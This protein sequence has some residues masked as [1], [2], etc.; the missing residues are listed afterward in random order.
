MS[1]LLS[2]L[3]GEVSSDV[4][5][6]L[7]RFYK[8]FN[9]ISALI[10]SLSLAILTFGEFRPATTQHLRVAEGLLAGSISTSIVSIMVAIILLFG[11]EGYENVTWTDRILAW[12]PL[13]FLDCSFLAFLVGLLLW[14]AEKNGDWGIPVFGSLA[15]VLFLIICS[16]ALNTCFIISRAG[17]RSKEGK[18]L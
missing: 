4:F 1:V 9:M 10:S 13:V 3:G 2:H 6:R 16:A 18:A 11:F 5:S 15:S 14:S 7:L 12:S 8:T 17:S